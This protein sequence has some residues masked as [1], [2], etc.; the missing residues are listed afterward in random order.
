MPK[1][2]GSLFI[3]E[4][5]ET[6]DVTLE[7]YVDG[8]PATRIDPAAT[9]I[10]EAIATWDDTGEEFT[11]AEYDRYNSEIDAEADLLLLEGNFD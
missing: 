5:E 9:W 2:T 6:R 8:Y 4:G 1:L 11:P 3:E 7:V 10:E